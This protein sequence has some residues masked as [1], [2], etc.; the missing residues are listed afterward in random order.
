MRAIAF[1]EFGGPEVLQITEFPDPVPKSGEVVVRVVATTV[2][3]TDVMMR[4]GLQ[5]A[6]M[7]HLKPP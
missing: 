7:T 1:N 4:S 5:A 2:N 6:L 3:P